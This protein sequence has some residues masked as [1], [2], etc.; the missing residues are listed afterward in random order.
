MM[1]TKRLYVGGLSHNI[2]EK[3]LK[4]RFGKF[5]EVSD[6]EVVTRKDEGGNPVK[7]FGYIN[8]NI[9]DDGFK[10]CLTVLNKSKWKG[11]TLQI[12]LAKESF[13]HRLA[14]ERQQAAENAQ[15]K[16]LN[17]KE[18][19]VDSLKKA[20]VE[21]F[22]MKAAVPGT[23]IPGHKD[24]IVS[25]FGRVLPVLNLKCEGKSKIFKYDPSKHCHNIKKF[26]TMTDVT[27]M[28]PVSQLTWEISGGD[29]EISKKRRGE[30]P[31]Q[32]TKPKKIKQDLSCPLDI[33]QKQCEGQRNHTISRLDMKNIVGGNRISGK[34]KIMHLESTLDSCDEEMV[35][36]KEV[37]QMVKETED[38][39]EVVGDDFIVKSSILQPG[40][41]KNPTSSGHLDS[42]QDYDSADTDEILTRS[43]ASG[44]PDSELN[45]YSNPG[46][47]GEMQSNKYE[48]TSVEKKHIIDHENGEK[49]DSDME[50]DSSMESDYEAMMTNC[51]RL[52]IS[53]GDLELL[54]KQSSETSDDADVNFHEASSK[55]VSV[56]SLKKRCINPEDILASIVGT[57]SSE[58]ESEGKKPKR[59]KSK[60]KSI[61]SLP[62]FI[63]TKSVFGVSDASEPEP[64]PCTKTE[65]SANYC[66]EEHK[67]NTVSKSEQCTSECQAKVLLVEPLC[68]VTNSE[69]NNPSISDSSALTHALFTEVSDS[70]E[71]EE[72]EEEV[73][74]IH[75]TLHC[76]LSAE[77][78]KD[79]RNIVVDFSKHD[80]N[81]ISEYVLTS[82]ETR[83]EDKS[84]VPETLENTYSTRLH[85]TTEKLSNSEDC[86]QV[87]HATKPEVISSKEQ[88]EES[89]APRKTPIRVHVCD[90]E[91]QRQDNE[92]RLAA[93]E[94]RQRESAQQK[95]V[96]QGS[97]AEV[98]TPNAN[99]GKHIVFDS[100]NDSEADVLEDSFPPATRGNNLLREDSKDTGRKN[101]NKQEVNLKPK[102]SGASRLFDSSEEE[103]NAL[104]EER[105][106]I[107]PQFEGKA[108]Q[109]LMELQSRFGADE[110]FQM[111]SR[112]M[113]SE[114]E[115]EEEEEDQL[116]NS[117]NTTHVIEEKL[118]EEKKKNM[119][120]LQSVLNISK[121]PS[122]AESTK[123]KIFRDISALHY[124]PTREDHAAFEKKKEPKTESKATR[125]KKLAEAEKL[126]E[127]SKDIFYDVAVD[128]KEVF[129]S[130]SKTV[131][132]EKDMSWDKKEEEVEAEKKEEESPTAEGNTDMQSGIFS[133]AA[134]DKVESSGFKFSFFGEDADIETDAN[135]ESGEYKIEPL[136]GPKVSWQ[137]DP[138]F[139]DSSSEDEDT[140]ENEGKNKIASVIAVEDPKPSKKMLFFFYQ[141]DDRLKEGPRTFCRP[142]KLE[143]Q[144]EEWEERR[145]SLI[146]EYRKKH[147]AAR[148]KLRESHHN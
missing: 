83:D 121:Q 128:L 109:K 114:E 63:G 84:D 89:R 64:I 32:K 124:D 97:L 137:G 20:G 30:F 73:G 113:D 69:C 129:G 104:D 110:R 144:R 125:R 18:R 138:R 24:W 108:G 80:K 77:N 56:K 16:N 47:L 22:H 72:G 33:H 131:E 43:K 112:F 91:K 28:T 65:D 12:E 37:P 67:S 36:T 107:K 95:K 90:A 123:S 79:E 143:D 54:A 62:E 46:L 134:P 21:N 105:F 57:C 26:D 148:K 71:E 75:S 6:V 98:D 51:C 120:I 92:R 87:K 130:T 9:S 3:D 49:S 25:K 58:D 81:S 140:E 44:A 17:Q 76:S 29:D 127:V 101:Q 68:S 50:S 133:L 1:L 19:L 42:D 60:K 14:M 2:S 88:D 136:R 4:D 119:E 132:G 39:L 141:D 78:M 100:D 115:K 8:I 31:P 145:T 126:P 122:F 139:Q 15:A 147:K 45:A 48:N 102:T 61:S 23:E 59:K 146:E 135:A 41:S 94:Q 82:Y 93:L 118:V 11:E 55:P 103:D 34:L 86:D 70:S 5:G 117:D 142:A 35:I 13:L 96:I 27:E 99:K 66:L 111:D 74:T 38:G 10:K 116:K 106:Q 40:E 52:E 85:K 7:T 53:L